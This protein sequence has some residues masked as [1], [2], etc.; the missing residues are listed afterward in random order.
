MKFLCKVTTSRERRRHERLRTLR[1]K[2]VRALKT[3]R[4]AESVAGTRFVRW[5]LRYP[6]SVPKSVPVATP[7][8]P[9]AVR[10]T[11]AGLSFD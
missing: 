9:R 7:S 6:K 11:P 3:L 2:T 8:Q 1:R 10:P 5:V 4:Q